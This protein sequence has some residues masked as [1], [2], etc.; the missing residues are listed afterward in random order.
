M[1][2]ISPGR[3]PLGAV[4]A[5]DQTIDPG[6]RPEFSTRPSARRDAKRNFEKWCNNVRG[7]TLG[8]VNTDTIV[9]HPNPP[10][11][12]NFMLFTNTLRNVSTAAAL[13]IG[14]TVAGNTAVAGPNGSVEDRVDEIATAMDQMGMMGRPL[15]AAEMGFLLEVS[16]IRVNTVKS[17]ADLNTK[18]AET[19]SFLLEVS[20]LR[21]P[22]ADTAGL[23]MADPTD[24]GFL[25]EISGLHK[26]PVSRSH[27]RALIICVDLGFTA[28]D[29]LANVLSKVSASKGEVDGE[30]ILSFLMS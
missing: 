22:Q 7:S 3:R 12:G 25:L 9:R 11:P 19:L 2:L 30:Q 10:T 16:G 23:K 6:F 26:Q 4:E 24:P 5:L 18:D 20:G 29:D 28:T 1:P 13:V 17:E 8:G 15:D 27:I 14:L 21:V